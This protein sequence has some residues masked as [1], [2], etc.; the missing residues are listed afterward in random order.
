MPAEVTGFLAPAF[1]HYPREVEAHVEVPLD[2]PAKTRANAGDRG[3]LS[4]FPGQRIVGSPGYV[5]E[6]QAAQVTLAGDQFARQ[7][8]RI[9]FD[10]GETAG[11]ADNFALQ[12]AADGGRACYSTS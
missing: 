10:V 11:I 6:E 8:G 9:E 3:L 12:E 7:V 1:V 5:T 4:F 2:I